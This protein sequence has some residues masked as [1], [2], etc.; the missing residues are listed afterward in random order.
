MAGCSFRPPTYCQALLLTGAPLRAARSLFVSASF[1]LTFVDHL[2]V[3]GG[4]EGR[5]IAACRLCCWG[6]GGQWMHAWE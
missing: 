5:I 4:G 3:E 2:R 6:G 1:L